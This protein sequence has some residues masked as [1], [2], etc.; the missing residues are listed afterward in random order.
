MCVCMFVC[1]CVCVCVCMMCVCVCVCE[2]NALGIGTCVLN[3]YPDPICLNPESA[4]ETQ[5]LCYYNNNRNH[6]IIL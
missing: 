6:N 3:I 4:S 5:S 1:V 2:C